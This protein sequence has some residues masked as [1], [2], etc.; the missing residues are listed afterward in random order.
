MRSCLYFLHTNKSQI[1]FSQNRWKTVVQNGYTQILLRY[2][3]R[4]GQHQNLG[5][6]QECRINKVN[7]AKNCSVGYTAAEGSYSS[8][9]TSETTVPDALTLGNIFFWLNLTNGVRPSKSRPSRCL[10]NSIGTALTNLIKHRC[11]VRHTDM[12][13]LW[14]SM[15][16]VQLH[17]KTVVWSKDDK[18]LQPSPD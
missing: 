6:L 2:H 15:D 1:T 7:M 16:S 10:R 14:S 12:L 8:P 4:I 13:W 5:T 17:H 3:K 18:Q 11:L 9:L